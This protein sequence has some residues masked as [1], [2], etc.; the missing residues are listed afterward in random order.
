MSHLNEFAPIAIGLVLSWFVVLGA[1]EMLKE[2]T[3]VVVKK[4]NAC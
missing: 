3:A 2:A 1:R 4:S